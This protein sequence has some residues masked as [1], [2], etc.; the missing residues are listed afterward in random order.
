MKDDQEGI[1]CINKIGLIRRSRGW[2]SSMRRVLKLLQYVDEIDKAVSGVA[3]TVLTESASE[4]T[5]HVLDLSMYG[6]AMTVRFNKRITHRGPIPARHGERGRKRGKW[7]SPPESLLAGG[8]FVAVGGLN[9]VGFWDFEVGERRFLKFVVLKIKKKF[10]TDTKLASKGIRYDPNFIATNDDFEDL[11]NPEVRLKD[12]KNVH[13]S[14]SRITRSRGKC[15]FY[16]CYPYADG[17]LADRV[18]DGVPRILN[19][20]VKYTLTYK[21]VKSAF[22]DIWQE[23]LTKKVSSMEKFMKSSFELIFRA[24]D[25]KNEPKVGTSIGDNDGDNSNEKDDE[26]PNVSGTGDDQVNDPPNVGQKNDVV[27]KVDHI[28][29]NLMDDVGKTID[30]VG[31]DVIGHLVDVVGEKVNFVSDCVGGHVD[32]DSAAETLKDGAWKKFPDL[33]FRS[34]H[35]AQTQK[36]GDVAMVSQNELDWS[37]FPDAEISKF[38]QPD[39]SVA[40]TDLVC[41]NIRKVD[42]ATSDNVKGI[43]ENMVSV[44]IMLDE[45]PAIPRRL[46]KP[47]AVCESPFL[48]KFDSGC[49]KVEGQSSKC[50]ENAQSRKNVLSIKHPFVKSITEQIDDMKVTLKFNRPVYSYSVNALRKHFD[51]GVDI[52]C[53]VFIAAFVEYLL[54]GLEISNHL[55]D[56]DAIRNRYGVLLSD[57]GK[58]KQSQYAVSEDEYT[59][60]L[61]KKK[62]GIGGSTILVD[63]SAGMCQAV[64]SGSGITKSSYAFKKV[65]VM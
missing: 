28:S 40:T 23:K 39:K 56:I 38:T 7:G 17:H 20:F 11:T 50:V 37:E 59:G 49:G 10:N 31:G 44:P 5:K 53:G 9:M 35:K 26:T 55:D 15:W 42:T 33:I 21:E 62:N 14:P 54:D 6:K 41:D 29:K 32:V 65:S 57:Y 27:P 25:I 1:T 46:R 48:S 34:S 30:C 45:T 16:E 3:L 2:M 36:E 60:R 47:V 24:L 51:Y 8:I 58:K 18:G 43:E 12:L 4:E 13:A 63:I 19:W 64:S 22:F 52:D 61:L